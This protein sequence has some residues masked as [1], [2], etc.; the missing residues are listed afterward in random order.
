MKDTFEYF[1]NAKERERAAIV[2]LIRTN[3]ESAR[4]EATEHLDELERLADTAGADVLLRM[5]QEKQL[6]DGA[7]YLGKG[8]VEELKKHVEM[9]SLQIVIFDDDLSPVQVRNLEKEL[10]IKVLDRSGLILDIFASRARTR[11]AK[12]Q[13]ELAQLE[14]FLPRLTRQWT[15]LSKQY[16]GIGTK[17]PGETQIETDRRLINTRISKLKEKLGAIERQQETRREGRSDELARV[18]LV[19]YTNAG[20]SSLLNVI[21]AGEVFVEDRLFA[22]LD[23]TTRSVGLSHGRKI[24]LTDTVGF[25]RKLPPKLIAS[26]RTTLAEVEQAD[27]LLHVVDVSH[28]DLDE[29]IAIVEQT[30]LELEVHDK[31]VIMVFNKTDLVKKED[32]HIFEELKGHFKHSVFISA[33]KGVGITSLKEEIE[34]VIAEASSEMTVE[35]PL[36]HFEIASRLHEL[37]EVK[38]REFGDHSVIMKLSVHHRNLARVER[39]LAKAA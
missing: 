32:R 12:T 5:T 15:H 39:L 2:V 30:L 6:P 25:I 21:S 17:G 37:A 13:I 11:E 26:F 7:L 19:G 16:G 18:A 14:Y 35:V 22:T 38:E 29:H 27:I 4:H 1:S 36:D 31:P 28:S 24:L 20:K 3:T 23:A 8:K 34:S 9:L 10:E 33:F